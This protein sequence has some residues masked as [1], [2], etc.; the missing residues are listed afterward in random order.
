MSLLDGLIEI[1]P[2]DPDE[3][4]GRPWPR[5][6]QKFEVVIVAAEDDSGLCFE[7]IDPPCE[8]HNVVSDF[9]F[10]VSR[11]LFG[12][13]PDAAG[14]WKCEI[15]FFLDSHIDWESGHEDGD[16]GFVIFKGEDVKNAINYYGTWLVPG[17][18]AHK[19]HTEGKLKELAEHMR[20]L[21]LKEKGA[22]GN[23]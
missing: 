2:A 1:A 23:G 17:S 13:L 20:E 19:L 5:P 22:K 4:E 16:F 11:H 12:G 10:G 7:L 14:L 8:V 18:V 3:S 9:G 15:G 6:G 21:N